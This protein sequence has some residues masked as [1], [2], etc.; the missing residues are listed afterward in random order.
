MRLPGWGAQSEPPAREEDR[1]D[2]RPPDR[3]RRVEP[4]EDC[5]G[6]KLIIRQRKGLGIIHLRNISSWGACGITDMPLAVGSLVF[7]ELRKGHFY[8]ARVRWVHRFTIG[9]NFARQMRPETV[10]RLVE[11]GRKARRPSPEAIS[12]H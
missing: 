7:F 3:E 1:K 9:V 10:Q 8:G 2:I 6:L 5:L 12:R 11:A 4:R